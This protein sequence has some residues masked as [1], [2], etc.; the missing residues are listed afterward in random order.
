[1]VSASAAQNGQIIWCATENL[2]GPTSPA[3]AALM[4]AKLVHLEN[5]VI[6]FAALE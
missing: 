2:C 3:A 1:M 4:T 6:I 5:K